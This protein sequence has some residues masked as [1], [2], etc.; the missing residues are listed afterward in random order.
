MGCIVE[1]KILPIFNFIIPR[2]YSAQK[3][4]IRLG[5]SKSFLKNFDFFSNFQFRV[6][7]MNFFSEL[8]N[9]LFSSK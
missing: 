9:L 1:M 8:L 3:C 5:F 7:G 6:K 2:K 4:H